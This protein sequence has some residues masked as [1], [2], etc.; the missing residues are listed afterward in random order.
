[1]GEV[2]NLFDS[3]L[4]N[5]ALTPTYR[6]L[7]RCLI[8]DIA[9]PDSQLYCGAARP[10]LEWKTFGMPIPLGT[11]PSP[12][13]GACRDFFARLL[14]G[15]FSAAS[16]LARGHV[17]MAPGCSGAVNI[18]LCTLLNPMDRVLLF[19]PY[20]PQYIPWIA[21][22]CKVP[23]VVVQTRPERG[24]E[25]APEDLEEALRDTDIRV[26]ILNSPNNPTGA[27]YS[28]QTIAG[29]ARVMRAALRRNPHGRPIWLLAD[30][31][32][33]NLADDQAKLF[34]LYR[35]TIVCYSLSKD[36]R[37][38]GLR[39][40]CAVVNPQIEQCAAVA[41]MLARANDALGFFGPHRPS[42]HFFGLLEKLIADRK[43]V[44]PEID[45]DRLNH[46]RRALC[47]ALGIESDSR[48]CARNFEFTRHCPPPDVLAATLRS[49]GLE[50]VGFVRAPEFGCASSRADYAQITVRVAQ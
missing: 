44:L 15:K 25:P 36:Y 32:F 37:L 19:A 3:D 43:F 1:M 17:V 6:H 24:W 11:P 23:P 21:N 38:A 13:Q 33:V 49:H 22:Y 9:D 29:I 5:T 8:A 20:Y 4:N 18:A 35:Y 48:G 39:V 16:P 14:A 10:H 12:G 27:V 7:L 28:P 31:V 40:G 46:P 2:A 26:V 30:A 34:D 50:L 42:Q 41:A 45:R 47:A